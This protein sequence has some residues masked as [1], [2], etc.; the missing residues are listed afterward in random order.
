MRRLAL[1]LPALA[2]YALFFA[3]PLAAILRL[4]FTPGMFSQGETPLS[5][6][7]DPANRAL[8]GFTAA[9]ALLSTGLTLLAGL[10][11]AWCFARLRFAGKP[12]WRALATVPFVLPAVVVAAGFHALLNQRGLLNTALGTQW[13]L[14][15]GL[16]AILLAHVFYNVSV[17]IR[18]VG[19]YL[20]VADPQIEEAAAV[21]GATRW[22]TVLRVTL[23]LAAPA[24]GA[25][26][27][28][29][30][31]FTLTSFGIVLLLGGPRYATVEVEI[32]T[33]TAQFLRLDVAA[34]LALLQM[35]VTLALGLLTA[36]LQSVAQEGSGAVPD[37][38]ARGGA[39]RALL[40]GSLVFI[41]GVLGAPL[42]ALVAR[43]LAPDGDL[44]RYYG[45]LGENTRNSAFFLPPWQA[46]RN[47]LMYAA[48]TACA[49]SALGVPLCY[50]L[51]A[52]DSDAP[53]QIARNRAARL[54]EALLLLPLGTSAVTL[55]LGYFIGLGALRTSPWLLPL[56]HTMIALPFFIRMLLPALRARDPRLAEAAASDGATGWQ[57]ARAI[58]LP[59]LAPALAAAAVFAFSISLGEFGAALL[60]SR[61]EYPTLP[62]AIYRF[63]SLPGA[64]NY[65]QAMAMSVILMAVTVAGA[66]LIER[67]DAR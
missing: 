55:G 17:V 47:S 60:I 33:Q 12:L 49:A 45:M 64:L 11:L 3:L 8:F 20:R 66:L 65:G 13:R 21:D 30:F 54:G 53:D 7:R 15:D 22:Q 14:L 57:I 6:L 63:L 38:Q 43:S 27:V 26:A 29:V 59:L 61:P 46:V 39:E 25:A 56:A 32:Y 52:R 62:V 4:S 51:A 23:P 41:T 1:A 36:R 44:L 10:P 48:F 50:A 2:F 37:R 16:G 5:V 34:S 42:L 35:A 18:V 58:E 9:Q 19:A 24:I 31:L 67:V 28:V 40:I